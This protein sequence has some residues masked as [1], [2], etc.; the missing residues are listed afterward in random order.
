MHDSQGQILL[1]FTFRVC[2]CSSCQERT[3]AS[4]PQPS[5]LE[6][7]ELVQLIT[8]MINA[9]LTPNSPEQRT[10]VLSLQAAFPTA[11][12]KHK[13]VSAGLALLKNRAAERTHMRQGWSGTA[14]HNNPLGHLLPLQAQ[15]TRLE[16]SLPIESST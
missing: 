15:E 14:R 6:D 7:I 2:Q 1:T 11:Y 10:R 16:I 3:L 13:T 12:N 9:A 8:P 4:S 5:C